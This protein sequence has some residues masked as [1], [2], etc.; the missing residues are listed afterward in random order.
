MCGWSRFGFQRVGI[1][2]DTGLKLLMDVKKDV[3]V[4]NGWGLALFVI[5][6]V[7]HFS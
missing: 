2:G 7:Y 6:K 1:L 3:V 5:S 4:V